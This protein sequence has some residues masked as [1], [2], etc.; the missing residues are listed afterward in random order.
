MST[1]ADIAANLP[2]VAEISLKDLR[3]ELKKGSIKLVDVLPVESYTSGHIPGSISLPLE[4]VT[5]RAE[6]FL[7]DRNAEIVVYCGKFT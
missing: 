2:H 4:E 3:K 5:A 6:E 7:P 1:Q